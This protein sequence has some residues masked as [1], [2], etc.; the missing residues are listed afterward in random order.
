MRHFGKDL[1]NVPLKEV[2]PLIY[3]SI[4]RII[5][6]KRLFKKFGDFE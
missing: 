4:D 1:S 6:F 3:Q 2:A 5:E